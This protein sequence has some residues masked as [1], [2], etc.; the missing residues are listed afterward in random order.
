MNKH[1]FDIKKKNMMLA[2]KQYFGDAVIDKCGA[3]LL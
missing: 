3:F 2:V 1:S